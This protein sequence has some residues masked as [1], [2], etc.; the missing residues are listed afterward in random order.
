M[1]MA[2]LFG[3]WLNGHFLHHGIHWEWDLMGTNRN[4][5]GLIVG[6]V[7]QSAQF[8]WSFPKLESLQNG[9]SY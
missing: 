5:W 7:R 4:K 8:I 6:Y 1:N 9:R 3:Y 2:N